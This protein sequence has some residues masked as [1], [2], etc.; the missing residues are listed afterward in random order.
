MEPI[1]ALATPPGLGAIALVRLSGDGVFS[2]S[3]KVIQGRISPSR[4]KPRRVYRAVVVDPETGDE[5][6]DVLF[7]TFHSPHSYTGED[8]VEVSTHGGITV[9]NMV[10]QAFLKAGAR[11]AQRGEFTKRAFLNGKLDL[12]EARA[13]LDLIEARTERGVKLARRKLDGWV[14]RRLEAINDRLLELAK[15]IEASINFE[16]D[17]GDVEVES[18]KNRL[19]EIIDELMRFI[20]E[21]KSGRAYLF[22]AKV[23]IV[24]R[25]NVGK[26]TLFNAILGRRRAIV[27]EV[28]GTTRDVVSEEIIIGGIP[29]KLMDTAGL[30]ETEDVVERIGVEFALRTVEESDLALLVV[31]ATQREFDDEVEFL[32][33]IEV[34]VIIVVNKLDLTGG[35][36]PELPAEFLSHR[37]VAISAETGEG[38]DRLLDSVSDM[39]HEIFNPESGFALSDHEL[40]R[41]LGAMLELD[42]G[43][44]RLEEGFPIDIASHHILRATSSLSELLGMGPVEEEILDRIFS[45]FCIGK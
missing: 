38:L 42:Q 15:D 25:P 19:R 29:V 3:D 27:T 4:A 28:P 2:I 10:L 34:P 5:I 11:L 40:N 24:G 35:Q 8:M 23:A 20:E 7:W 43:L 39:L 30:R 36:L 1:V 45:D 32:S 21:G 26:S 16:E 17:V 14:S 31:D 33:S 44:K 9:S 13:V 12:I 6:D 41:A 22:G 18:I 37:V